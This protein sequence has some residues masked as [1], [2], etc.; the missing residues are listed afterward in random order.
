MT[1]GL[2]VWRLRRWPVTTWD[3]SGDERHGQRCVVL[4]RGVGRGPRNVLVEFDDGTKIV[5][6]RWC[7]RLAQGE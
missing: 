5:G 7:V 4:A 3:S 1:S 6:T 2:Y